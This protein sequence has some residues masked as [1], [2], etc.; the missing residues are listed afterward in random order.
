MHLDQQLIDAATSLLK[1][2]YPDKGGIA[3][4]MYTEHGEILTG[5][6]FNP[7]WG[8]GLC[9]ETGPILEAV[10]GKTRI[11]ATVCVGRL[12]GDSPIV[13]LTPCGIC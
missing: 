7:D 11:V 1:D 8:G 5:V 13:I 6:M 9:A 3:A 4:A 12:E 10:K 2:Y